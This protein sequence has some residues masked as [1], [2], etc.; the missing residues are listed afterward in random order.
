MMGVG[1][2]SYSLY[3]WSLPLGHVVESIFHGP[4]AVSAVL[5]ISVSFV[6]AI[7]SYRF[8]ERQFLRLKERLGRRDRRT[9]G[10]EPTLGVRLAEGPPTVLGL[11]PSS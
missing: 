8:V 4:Q 5:Q 11:E 7:A 6:A 3:L 10:A 2:L 9:P 1:R